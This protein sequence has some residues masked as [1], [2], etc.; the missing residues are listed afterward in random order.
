LRSAARAELLW[1]DAEM[2]VEGAREGFVRAVAGVERYGEDIAGA[3]G[4]DAG[5]FA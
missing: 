4:E 2:L 5:C 3:A 1:C